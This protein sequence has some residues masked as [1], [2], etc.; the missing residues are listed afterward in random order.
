[1]AIFNTGVVANDNGRQINTSSLSGDRLVNVAVF[2]ITSS[3]PPI[4]I[5]L[6]AVAVSTETR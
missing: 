4:N 1:M 3:I 2:E 5:Q 6:P